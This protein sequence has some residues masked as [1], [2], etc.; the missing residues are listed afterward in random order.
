MTDQQV[1]AV[2]TMVGLLFRVGVVCALVIYLF[3]CWRASSAV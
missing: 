1:D 2:D 3:E